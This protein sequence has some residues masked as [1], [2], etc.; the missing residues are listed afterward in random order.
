MVRSR[1]LKIYDFKIT[2]KALIDIGADQN[3]IQEGL[4]P[5]K[6]FEKTID[7]LR[8][9]NNNGLKNNYKSSKVHVCNHEIC[10][11]NFFLLVKDL[12]QE[13]ILGTSF[14]TQLYPSKMTE[15]GLE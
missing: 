13:L 14:I 6:Y 9:A 4:I 8:G 1:Y 3:C 11:V 5:T 12:G 7:G 15:K 10:F 2:L